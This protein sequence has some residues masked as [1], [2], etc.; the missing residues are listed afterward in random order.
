MLFCINCLHCTF[1]ALQV[2]CL[3]PFSFFILSSA[4]SCFAC[5]SGILKVFCFIVVL[6]A[7]LTSGQGTADQ[8][9]P[10]ANTGI[11]VH[12]LYKNIQIN[13]WKVN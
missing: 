9:S 3:S 11:N 1:P 10:L 5:F 6:M 8:I 13:V 4:A 12:C 2:L 7:N